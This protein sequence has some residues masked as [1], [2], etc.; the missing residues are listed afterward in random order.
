MGSILSSTVHELS[1]R[2]E[3]S[4][5]CQDSHP[6]PLGEKCERYLGTMQPPLGK[7]D[8]IFAL[9]VAHDF[10]GTSIKFQL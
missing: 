10:L 3:K 6:G 7:L 5:Q 2:D 9:L 1:S 8:L 4:W